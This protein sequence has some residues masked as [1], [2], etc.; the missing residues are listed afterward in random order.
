[1]TAVPAFT[2]KLM[3]AFR[4]SESDGGR[5]DIAS[6][7]GIALLAMLAMSEHGERSRSWLQDKLWGTRGPAQGRASLRTELLGL[8]RLLNASETELLICGRDRIALNLK[9][10]TV[11]ARRMLDDA[12][13]DEAAPFLADSEFLEGLDIPGEDGFEDWLR[14][15]RRVLTERTEQPTSQALP[16]RIVD[17]STP[18][19]GF[20][21]RPALAVLPFLNLT[22]DP[23]NDYLAEG[24]SEELISRLSRLRWLPVIS[25]WSSFAFRGDQDIDHAAIGRQLGAKYLFEGRLRRVEESFSLAVEL[26]EANTSRVVWSHRLELPLIRSREVQT[27][28]IASLVGALDTRIDAA[29]Q[30]YVPRDPEPDA[31]VSDLIWRGRWHVNRLTRADAARAREL[32]DRALAIEPHSSEALIQAAWALARWIWAERRPQEDVMRLRALAQRAINA[33]PE[34]GRAHLVAG[35]AEMFLRRP[36]RAKAQLRQA[37]E[38]SPSLAEAHSVLGDA[39]CWNAEPELALESLRTAFRLSPNDLVAFAMLGNM[40]TAHWML[41]A[42]RE[43]VDHAEQA[44]VRQP[45]FWYAHGVKIAALVDMGD[46][47]AAGDAYADLVATKPRFSVDAVDW[48]PF[49]DRAWNAKLKRNLVQAAGAVPVPEE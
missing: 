5:I 19:P 26:S 8:R 41:G 30:I 3:G 23:E 10:V 35:A 15:Q 21:G 25:R 20:G 13:V 1:V 22:D 11:D 43:A 36:D 27:E 34:D 28:I 2:L 32:F 48:V 18:A 12:G 7:K 42:W 38:L 39:L 44:I 40:A 14:N 9:Q 24:L 6:R 16:A 17:V 33:D 31:S 4:L 46:G 47:E 29:E 45:G 49:V 37:C